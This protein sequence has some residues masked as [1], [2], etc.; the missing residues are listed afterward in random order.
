[1]RL[2]LQSCL[3]GGVIIACIDLHSPQ[4]D[5]REKYSLVRTIHQ[6]ELMCDKM[7]SDVMFWDKVDHQLL[8]CGVLYA[9]DS[10]QCTHSSS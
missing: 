2:M 8:L 7:V 6:T 4:F 1:M 5:L 3:N 10:E 9:P